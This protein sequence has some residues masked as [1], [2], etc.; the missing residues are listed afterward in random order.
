MVSQRK[1]A[2]RGLLEPGPV[3][4][5][6]MPITTHL[7]PSAASQTQSHAPAST[8]LPVRLPWADKKPRG[9]WS[10]PR[11]NRRA[12]AGAQGSCA[13]SSQTIASAGLFL[14][15]GCPSCMLIPAQRQGS[16][17]S[18]TAGCFRSN[19]G[20]GALRDDP[21]QAQLA[22]LGVHECSLGQQGVT[23]QNTVDAGERPGAKARPAAPR[24]AA[25]GNPRSCR[26]TTGGLNKSATSRV[27]VCS[28]CRRGFAIPAAAMND[29]RICG[30]AGVSQAEGGGRA[31]EQMGGSTVR[32]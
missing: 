18:A 5:Q 32:F 13:P 7:R 1:R 11:G 29:R 31:G 4:S 22:G 3:A 10:Q 20:C 12:C 6:N 26:R 30:Q 16:S 23:E 9:I 28:D 17:T 24:S 27:C 14:L 2:G 15:A 8:C 25:D 21:L 19:I